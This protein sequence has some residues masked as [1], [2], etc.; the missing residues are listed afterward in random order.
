[1]KSSEDIV[2]I[3][4]K[5]YTL[6][7]NFQGFTAQDKVTIDNFAATLEAYGYNN[8]RLDPLVFAL[9]NTGPDTLRQGT[10][11]ICKNI[12]TLIAYFLFD[13]IDMD[14]NTPAKAIHLFNLDGIYVPLSSF[15]FAAYDSL[16]DFE[17][18]SKDYVS[19][20]YRP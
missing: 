5:N 11:E 7:N 4:A 14:L 18:A 2:E 3:S 17:K 20:S 1:M 19:V 10:D 12:S 16:K 8:E 6:G 13:D 9:L 15:L